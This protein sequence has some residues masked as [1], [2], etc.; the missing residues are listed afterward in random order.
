MLLRFCEE[1]PSSHGRNRRLRVVPVGSFL[2]QFFPSPPRTVLYTPCPPDPSFAW[3]RLHRGPGAIALSGVTHTLCT[4]GAVRVLTE[5]LTAP[6]EPYDAL[7]CTSSAVVRMVREVIGAYADYL[8]D[9]LGGTP[10]LRPRLET[11][12]LGVNPEK[13]RPATP[14]ERAAWR[15]RLNISDEEVAILFVG[16]FTP[17]AKAHPFP[18]FQGLA[19]AAQATGQRVHLVLS[20]WAPNDAILRAFVEGLGAFAPGIPVSVADGMDP[21]FRFGVWHAADLFTSLSDSI[22]ETFGLVILEAMASGLPVVAADWDGYR[23]LVSDG[24]TGFLVPTMMVRDATADA[25]MRLLLRAIDY[26]GFLAECNQTVIVDPVAAAEAYARLLGDANL[27]RS[28]GAAGRQR[29]QERFAWNRVV[30]AYEE[31]WCSQETQRRAHIDRAGAAQQTCPA[32]VRDRSPGP[33]CYPAPEVSFAGYPTRLLNEDARVEAV[34]GAEAELARLLTLP[35]CNYAG[36]RR[37]GDE[38]VLRSLLAAAASPRTLGELDDTQRGRGA[39]GGTLRATL[40]WLLKYGLLRLV[41]DHPSR[42]Q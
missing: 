6:Y 31:L 27:R 1:H 38:A 33:P 9:R 28:M 3:A 10:A 32:G 34:R 24:E 5:L 4:V 22:Q 15:A 20:G 17:H 30:R 14:A 7:I 26:D 18:M 29:V 41:E 37:V 8:R 12:P 42:G 36:E 39:A 23:D 13:F 21:H 16:R 2:E 40:A 25:T 35:L 19:R 11:I